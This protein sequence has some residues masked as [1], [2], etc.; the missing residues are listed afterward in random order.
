MNCDQTTESSV[1]NYRYVA[2]LGLCNLTESWVQHGQNL[3]DDRGM[4]IMLRSYFSHVGSNAVA[5]RAIFW[6][7]ALLWRYEGVLTLH[8][9]KWTCH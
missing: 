4:D 2:A 9:A 8:T 6:R 3:L 7:G 5:Y 1:N